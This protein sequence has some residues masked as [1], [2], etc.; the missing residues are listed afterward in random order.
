MKL[1][2]VGVSLRTTIF[3]SREAVAFLKHFLPSGSFL[4]QKREKW[5]KG[6]N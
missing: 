3:G 6:G 1:L 5:V 4:E 2:T